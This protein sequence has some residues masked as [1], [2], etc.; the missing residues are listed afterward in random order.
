MFDHVGALVDAIVNLISLRFLAGYNRTDI[1]HK[2]HAALFACAAF[3]LFVF[4]SGTFK[5]QRRVAARTKSRNFARVTRTL[6]AFDHALRNRL[7]VEGRSAS[8]SRANRP[9]GASVCV[10]R[11]SYTRL[12]SP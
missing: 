10:S 6:G 2:I 8:N 12:R 9:P 11:R 5:T 7:S 4:A 1:F 3:A